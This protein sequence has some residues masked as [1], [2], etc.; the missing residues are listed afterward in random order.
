MYL[1]PHM[2]CK[3]TKNIGNPVIVE[4][5]GMLGIGRELG[6]EKIRITSAK[7]RSPRIDTKSP[8]VISPS[9]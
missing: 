1:R 5:P 4:K 9:L 6:N 2:I 3:A 7:E 8:T